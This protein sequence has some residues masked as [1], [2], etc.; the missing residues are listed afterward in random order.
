MGFVVALIVG[1][2]LGMML[3]IHAFEEEIEI[4]RK[5]L[6]KRE[7]ENDKADNRN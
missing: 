7:I 1:F 5:E 6:L 2:V 3:A 4:G